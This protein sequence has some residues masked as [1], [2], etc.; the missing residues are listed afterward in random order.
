MTG[1]RDPS[2]TGDRDATVTGRDAPGAGERLDP[3]TPLLG[4]RWLLPPLA[5][6]A[7][8]MIVT[9]GR[10]ETG[11]LIALG[12]TAAVFVLLT[13]GEVARWATTRYRITRDRLELR[14]GLA[15]RTR[16]VV[17]RDRV[18]SVDLTASVFHRVLGLAAVRVGTGQDRGADRLTLNAL[19]AARA[20]ALRAELLA[21]AATSDESG[22]VARFSPGWLRYALLSGWSVLIGLV[23]FGAFF[24]LLDVIG[25][26][27]AEVSALT[28]LW[29]ALAASP[30]LGAA[31]AV[32]VILLIGELGS[33]L[34]YAEAW[35]GYRLVREPSGSYLVR[36]G[37]LTTRSL[38]LSAH[39]LRG[40]E[41][42]EPLLLRWG[43]GARVTAVATGLPGKSED[44]H[45]SRTLLPPS[46]RAEALRVLADVLAHVPA[47]DG[48]TAPAPGGES[49]TAGA[50]APAETPRLEEL[51]L[52]AHPRA[53]LRR[54]VV[55]AAVATA[56]FV[57]PFGAA[58]ALFTWWPGW[59]WAAPGVFAAA[60]LAFAFDAH[61]ALGHTVTPRFL[62]I[63]CGTFRRRTVALD[64]AAVIGW[65]ITR[66]PFQRRAGLAT[67][68]AATAAGSGVY[69]VRDIAPA[70]AL[71][72]ADE[73]APGTAPGAFTPF[74]ISPA[75]GE[76]ILSEP[77]HEG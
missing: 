4:L 36:R 40:A 12:I 63:R 9:G 39:R 57:V 70:R 21:G 55:R 66:S 18:R 34:L 77:G 65:T 67:L 33:V 10:P 59:A 25:V 68:S 61:R 49:R 45:E 52:R 16:T 23:P 69:R 13:L 56:V 37:L 11:A 30:L 15:H 28:A 62:V 29:S 8:A 24:R 60:A 35:W 51:R 54:R 1:D 44:A 71:A 32:A 20:A 27:P 75:P 42:S 74:R 46:P 6:T 26:N 17:P 73:A 3:R 58:Q 72:L 2:V 47:R 50:P 22:H 38:T 31:I 76:R 5:S 19:P 7:V 64:R 43:R 14:T 48:R 41:L 53:A